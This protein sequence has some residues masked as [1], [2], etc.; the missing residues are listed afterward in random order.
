MLAE[1]VE[2]VQPEILG[3]INGPEHY[4][5]ERNLCSELEIVQYTSMVLNNIY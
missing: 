1:I 4:I 3:E 5:L 2:N